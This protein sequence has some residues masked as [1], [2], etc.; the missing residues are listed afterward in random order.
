MSPNITPHIIPAIAPPPRSRFASWVFGTGKGRAEM[1]GGLACDL[2]STDPEED[3][4]REALKLIVA[5][6]KKGRRM[7]NFI[8]VLEFEYLSPL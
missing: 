5:R 7:V 3:V 2:G 8:L 4:R 6:I 1:V